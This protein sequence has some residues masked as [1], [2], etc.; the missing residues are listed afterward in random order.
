V[1]AVLL[2]VVV[3]AL[4]DG[5]RA[6]RLGNSGLW[7]RVPCTAIG[8]SGTFVG[9]SEERGDGF[10]VMRR[11]LLQRLLIM[12]PLSESSDNGG[13]RGTRYSPSYLGEAGDESPEGLPRFLPY[14][15][16]M[17][18]HV[19]LLISTGKVRYEPCTELFPGVDGPRGEIHE[20]GPG[21]PGQGYMEVTCHYGS[22]S[23]GCRN[24][25]DINLQKFRRVGRTIILLRQVWPE[26][27]WSSRRAEVI[28]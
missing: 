26:L 25:G 15:M 17:S 13:I 2:L 8:S 24:S 18:L 6:T 12:H 28:R 4:G 16:E 3:A 7:Y 20:P 14:G 27:G 5:T 19:M 10:H 21:R 9:Q 22:V 11:Q 23:N 1:A